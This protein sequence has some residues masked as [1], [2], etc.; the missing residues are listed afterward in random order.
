MTEK[1]VQTLFLLAAILILFVVP[2][3]ECQIY[4][5]LEGDH[6]IASKYA[7]DVGIEN[8]PAV[9]FVEDFEESSVNEMISRWE[10][11][12]DVQ[13][14]SFDDDTPDNSSGKQSLIITHT[15]GKGNGSQLYRRLQP[16]YKQI[17]ARTYVKFDPDCA[18]IHHFG[19]HLG[20]FNPSTPWPQG[21][22][23]VRPDGSKRFTS[24]VEPYG[25]NWNWDFYSYWQGMHVHGDGNYWGTPFLSGSPKPK[26]QLGE[27]MCVEMMIKVNDPVTASNGEQ[28]FW[29]N[30]NLWRVDEQVVSHAGKGFPNGKWSG[31]WWQPDANAA[32]TFE[33]FQWRSVD[34]LLINYIW[35]YVYITKAPQG[36]ISKIWFDD[37]VVAKEYIGPIMS[38][39]SSKVN[40]WFEK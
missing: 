16:G 12:V 3:A 5:L 22:A 28:A 17:Y 27:W 38:T 25:T 32:E 6:G 10:T 36:H 37:I 19:T 1:P 7:G 2:H 13:Y 23:G 21:G 11:S 30:G 29:I 34:E 18:Q 14:M 31:G 33:G 35:T 20:G 26:V 40:E 4:P 39:D 9:I 8:D 24:G 15:G